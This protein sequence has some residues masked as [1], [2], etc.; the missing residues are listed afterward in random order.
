MVDYFGDFQF[1]MCDEAFWGSERGNNDEKKSDKV[2]SREYIRHFGYDR[3]C[4][5]SGGITKWKE[6]DGYWDAIG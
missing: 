2:D 5:S 1:G 6:S 3:V 4:K